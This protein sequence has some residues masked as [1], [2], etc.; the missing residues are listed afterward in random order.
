MEYRPNKLRHRG[1][2][3]IELLVSLSIFSIGLSLATSGFAA[4]QSTARLISTANYLVHLVHQARHTALTRGVD[5]ALCPSQTGLQ[6]TGSADWSAGWI[7]FA[8]TDQDTPVRVDAG[9]TVLVFGQRIEGLSIA[10]NREAFVFRPYGRR[11]TAG[12]LVI[13]DARRRGTAVI[14]SY[15]GKPRTAERLPSGGALQCGRQT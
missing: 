9:E 3:L 6:C 15:T 8:N 1:I 13:C 5:I 4:L 12:T 11:A 14:I 2:S 7:M 10:A